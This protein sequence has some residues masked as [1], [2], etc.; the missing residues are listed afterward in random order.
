MRIF[1]DFSRLRFLDIL[2]SKLRILG[3]FIREVHEV[4][5]DK[6]PADEDEETQRLHPLEGVLQPAEE[7]ARPGDQE[8]R[9]HQHYP[10]LSIWLQEISQ[11]LEKAAT[12]AF[13]L[14]KT[15]FA[16]NQ[17]AC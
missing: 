5:V 7:G 8:H 11:C 6:D 17:T 3:I 10:H 14:L 15:L 2:I 4:V 13:S 12:R 16:T 9:P 1:S